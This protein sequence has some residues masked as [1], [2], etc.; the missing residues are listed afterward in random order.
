MKLEQERQRQQKEEQKNYPGQ[1]KVQAKTLLLPK[2]PRLN[3]NSELLKEKKKETNKK[4]HKKENK[5]KL[6]MVASC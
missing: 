3:F 5:Q 6:C 1:R 4:Q 2:K